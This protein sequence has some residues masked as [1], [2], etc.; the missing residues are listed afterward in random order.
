EQADTVTV[1]SVVPYTMLGI[2]QDDLKKLVVAN[3]ESQIDK[4]KQVI[5]DDGVADAKFSQENPATATSAVV[6]VDVDSVAGPDLNEEELKKQVAGKKSA[7]IKDAIK[8]LPGVTDV[9]VKYRPF[10]VSTAPNNVKKI[11]IDIAKPTG[12]N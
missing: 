2:K 4:D 5:L 1:T 8:Q 9:E 7:D 10:W 12:S 11:T 6:K 3:V